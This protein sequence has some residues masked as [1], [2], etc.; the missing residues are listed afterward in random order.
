MSDRVTILDFFYGETREKSLWVGE[1]KVP[2]VQS[3]GY[4]G[5]QI[6]YTIATEV[7]V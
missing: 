4:F 2:T 7:R 1:P 5:G 6:Q 3:F